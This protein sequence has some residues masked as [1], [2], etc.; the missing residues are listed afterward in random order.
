MSLSSKAKEAIVNRIMQG[1]ANYAELGRKH[2]VSRE[3]IRQLAYQA[4]VTGREQRAERRDGRLSEEAES[5]VYDRE[6]YVPPRWS[7]RI[8]TRQQFEA[9]LEENDSALLARWRKAQALPI[10]RSGHAH[11]NGQ[12]CTDCEQWKRW[13]EFYLDSS[14]I[15]GR[16]SRCQECARAQAKEA[17]HAGRES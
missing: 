4:G 2:G 6:M 1:D 14:R 16:S 17:Y 10:S 13:D 9:F 11:P 12:R 8:Y 7:E 3:Y 5:L 15:Y